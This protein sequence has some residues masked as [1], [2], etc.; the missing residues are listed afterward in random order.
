[1]SKNAQA[2]SRARLSYAEAQPLFCK[3]CYIVS[4]GSTDCLCLYIFYI[5]TDWKK[6]TACL[7]VY[8][9]L[10]RLVHV[11]HK[12]V[13]VSDQACRLSSLALSTS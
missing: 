2:E 6:E 11:M 1:M 7:T 12:F 5:L 13:R 10:T 8:H 4:D 3:E 9:L